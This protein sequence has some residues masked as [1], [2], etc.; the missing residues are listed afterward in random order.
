MLT[1][2]VP[3][4]VLHSAG[5]VMMPVCDDD[6]LDAGVELPQYLFQTADVFRH[7]RFSSVYQHSPGI[8]SHIIHS[9]SIIKAL[10]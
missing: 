1:S 10:K 3:A 4:D 6:L 9:V 5:V 7:S 8:Q 2:D